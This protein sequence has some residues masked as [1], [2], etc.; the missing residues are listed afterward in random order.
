MKKIMTQSQV[1]RYAVQLSYDRVFKPSV[2]NLNSALTL[3]PHI[4]L[5]AILPRRTNVETK[6]KKEKRP[7][8][9]D[10][11]QAARVEIAIK[12]GRKLPA[13]RSK[14]GPAPVALLP[15]ASQS[16]SEAPP[17]SEASS[18]RTDVPSVKGPRVSTLLFLD[19]LSMEP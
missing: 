3:I 7:P 12:Q 19:S 10:A 17:I 5:A 6:S 2:Y 1:K 4:Q 16:T 15:T 14:K 8:P 9:R 18:S 11:A 13:K